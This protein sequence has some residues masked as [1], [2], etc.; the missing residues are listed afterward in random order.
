[1]H[2]DAS[3]Q[4]LRLDRRLSGRRGWIGEEELSRELERL[5]DVAAKGD[6]IDAPA[7]RGRGESSPQGS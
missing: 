1:V 3:K 7:P 5:P 2:D 4:L 6:L